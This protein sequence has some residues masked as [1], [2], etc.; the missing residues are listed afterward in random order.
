MQHLPFNTLIT[1]GSEKTRLGRRHFVVVLL[2]SE[3][4]L[5]R[6]KWNQKPIDIDSKRGR[7][8]YRDGDTDRQRQ[9]EG[10]K[11]TGKEINS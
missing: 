6:E 3:G 7:E 9:R 2:I 5:E 8:R 10:K 4:D 1:L 11:E